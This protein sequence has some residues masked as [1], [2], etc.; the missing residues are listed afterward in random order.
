M[1]YVRSFVDSFS[2]LAA[3]LTGMK[4]WAWGKEQRNAFGVLKEAIARAGILS[5]P[6]YNQQCF[7][8]ADT[9]KTGTG[10]HALAV[11]QG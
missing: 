8:Q 5:N 10:G 2:M 1:G 3:P 6:K 9:S 7:V 11:G 4:H